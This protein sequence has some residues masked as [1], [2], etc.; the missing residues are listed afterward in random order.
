MA[1]QSAL[2]A[3]RSA[4][5]RPHRSSALHPVAIAEVPFECVLASGISPDP[6]VPAPEVPR[7]REPQSL[8]RGLGLAARAR[9]ADPPGRCLAKNRPVESKT[10]SSGP[11]LNLAWGTSRWTRIPP[12][13]IIVAQNSTATIRAC[14][15]S[16]W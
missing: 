11:L 14:C 5:E 12:W 7:H 8:A 4:V 10:M 6:Q 13:M 1:Q 9:A 3:G 15:Q 16:G 2:D